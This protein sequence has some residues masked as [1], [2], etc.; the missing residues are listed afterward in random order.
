MDDSFLAETRSSY[1]KVADSYARLVPGVEASVIDRALIRAFADV[2]AGPVVE[3]GCGTGRVAAYLDA[4]GLD[5]TGIDLSPGMLVIARRD[6]PGL[7][8][9]EGSILD[10]ELPDS[11]VAGVIAW[12]S[13]IHLPPDRLPMAF[14]EFA[15]ILRPGGHLQL[16]FHVGDQRNR[17]TEG[18]GHEDITLDVYLLPVDRV[19]TL[20]GESGFE[21]CHTTLLE[22][23]T[24]FTSTRP[25]ARLLAR[26][27]G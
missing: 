19:V 22:P 2:V 11:S 24:Y 5:V 13:I 17:K 3:V 7:R 14:A 8:F 27:P 21:L 15:R 4:L 18:Y 16:A 10:L 12:Y 25:Q 23:G 1:D 6:H 9:I 26:R 20:L